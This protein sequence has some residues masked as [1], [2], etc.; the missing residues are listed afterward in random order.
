MGAYPSMDLAAALSWPSGPVV[1]IV[2]LPSGPV[3]CIVLFFNGIFKNLLEKN[4]LASFLL[5][6]P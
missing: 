5:M 6:A 4:P 3:A 2:L 1:C